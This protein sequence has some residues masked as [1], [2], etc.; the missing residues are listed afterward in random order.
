MQKTLRIA[1]QVETSRAHG[2]ALAEGIADTA[3]NFG[4]WRLESV[5]P[6]LLTDPANVRRYDGLIVRVMDSATAD[7]ILRA[8]RP[9][10]DTYGRLDPNPLPFIRLD[11]EAIARHAAECFAEHRYVRCAYCG[12][13]GLRFSAARG[14][15]FARLVSER[16]GTCATYE[17]SGATKY[18]DTFVRNER[19]DR[20]ADLAPL[21][22]WVKS[23]PK[24]IAIF[25]CN[26]IRA[27]HLMQACADAKIDVPREVAV[28]GVDN[29]KVLCM[30]SNPPLSSIDTNAFALGQTAAKMLGGLIAPQG[31]PTTNVLHR[32]NGIAERTSTESYPVK[33]PWLSDALVYIRR[34]LANGISA[35]DVTR[36]IGYSHTAV[37]NAFRR[38][39]GAS[40]HQE[41]IRQRRERA[42]RMLMETDMT[43]AEIA[44]QCGYPSAQYFAHRFA[45]EFG[46]TPTIW[47]RNSR[48]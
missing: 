32:P 18:R 6:R 13:P 12:F 46:T 35:N 38:E 39:I 23:L 19:M 16:G 28:L 3:L 2:R 9:A 7:A 37:N 17:G 11:D 34:N 8:K 48:R 21:R 41:I 1:V 15:A 27:F 20:I 47:R 10:V 29:D 5:E 33:T 26:D 30:F 40:V 25:C 45:S 44:K 4:D 22:K 31:R 24:P 43:A 42:C 14:E 36:R